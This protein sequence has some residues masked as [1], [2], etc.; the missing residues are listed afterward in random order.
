MASNNKPEEFFSQFGSPP[1][2]GQSMEMPSSPST[3]PFDQFGGPPPSGEEMSVPNS[4][5]IK[6]DPKAEERDRLESEV[7]QDEA[8]LAMLP[9]GSEEK[10]QATVAVVNKRSR[11]ARTRKEASD[12][13]EDVM[14]SPQQR[15]M[16]GGNLP[17][18]TMWAGS[19][20][21]SSGEA[22][23]IFRSPTGEMYYKSGGYVSRIKDDR[24]LQTLVSLDTQMFSSQQRQ[25]TN[26]A[27]ESLLESRANLSN[28]EADTFRF[29]NQKMVGIRMEGHKANLSDDQ[30]NRLLSIYGDS[31]LMEE[32]YNMTPEMAIEQLDTLD[33]LLLAGVDQVTIDRTIGALHDKRA[34]MRAARLADEVNQYNGMIK[35]AHT[36]MRSYDRDIGEIDSTIEGLMTDERGLAHSNPERHEIALASAM[37]QRDDLIRK[38]QY[39][40]NLVRGYQ[41]SRAV[42][43]SQFAGSSGGPSNKNLDS[44]AEVGSPEYVETTQA[45][46]TLYSIMDLVARD[47]GYDGIDGL[48]RDSLAIA[49]GSPDGVRL[50]EFVSECQRK[51][52]SLG[53]ETS[54]ENTQMW[55]KSALAHIVQTQDV[56]AIRA[57]VDAVSN[58][59]NLDFPKRDKSRDSASAFSDGPLSVPALVSKY[60]YHPDPPILDDENAQW[61]EDL[62][63]KLMSDGISLADATAIGKKINDSGMPMKDAIEAVLGAE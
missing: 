31:A 28:Q 17:R 38:R 57:I 24:E 2:P 9:E 52:R 58:T 50:G 54:S 37:R 46:G 10:K 22:P 26:S 53:W 23:V 20:T 21:Y 49:L 6:P 63:A 7:Q 12:N 11:L 36:A 15:A 47:N 5:L 42:L 61:G 56:E 35:E 51:A 14:L 8:A 16:A 43:Q 44:N 41:N 19:A 18:G 60:Q 30:L 1:E 29:L 40:R 3:N 34:Q 32:I 59:V 25:Q 4:P 62:E 55:V 33:G 48:H 45:K 27:K 13:N 39:E